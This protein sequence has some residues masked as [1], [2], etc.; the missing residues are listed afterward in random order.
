MRNLR[1]LKFYTG[2]G[3]KEVK[4]EVNVRI[5]DDLCY[6]CPK[7]RLLHWEAFPSRCMPS[8]FLPENLVELV[9]EAS[10]LEKLW[11]EAQVRVEFEC[12]PQN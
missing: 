1:F 9:M 11:S 4:K 12:Y 8:N 7:L 3:N 5:S 10:K 2:L 6:L